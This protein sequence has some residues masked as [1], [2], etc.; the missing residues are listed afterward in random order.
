[1][2]KG[3]IVFFASALLIAGAGTAVARTTTTPTTVV[4]VTSAPGPGAKTGFYGYLDTS[5][6]CRANRTVKLFFQ[7]PTG[8]KLI[9]TDKSSLAGNWGVSGDTTGA[10]LGKVVATRRVFGP[11]GHR[12][13]CQRDSFIIA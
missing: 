10:G 2:K 11:R 9:D 12:H 1:M 13:V 5:K 3:I 8:F 4:Y 7:Y 6:K